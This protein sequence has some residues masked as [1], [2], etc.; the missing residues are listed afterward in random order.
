MELNDSLFEEIKR[1]AAQNQ[2]TL[3]AVLE[4]ALHNFLKQ[5]T[6]ATVPFRMRRATFAGTGLQSGIEEG[7][8][9]QI[10][11]RIYEEQGG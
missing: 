2:T 1:Y 4:N 9:Q 3:R 8:W 6:V 7:N 11:S 10:R 5:Q